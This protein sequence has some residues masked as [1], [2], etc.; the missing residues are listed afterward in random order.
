[1]LKVIISESIHKLLQEKDSLL[2]RQD[3]SVFQT[4]SNDETMKIHLAEKANLIVTELDMP[5]M[6]SELLYS[7]IRKDKELQRV[8]VLMICPNNMKSIER[9]SHC[10]ADAIILRPVNPALILAKA[11]QLLDLSWRD[12]YRARVLINGKASVRG[13]PDDTALICCAHNI[14]ST[15]VLFETE[16]VLNEGDQVVCSFFLPGGTEVQVAGEIVRTVHHAP[17][18]TSNQYGVRFSNLTAEARQA[19]ETFIQSSVQLQ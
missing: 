3:I 2:N 10:M 4:R 19:L 18:F 9:C 13:N 17:R 8:A 12:T 14:S 7:M 15:G 5:G 16:K 11:Q 6:D 1:M